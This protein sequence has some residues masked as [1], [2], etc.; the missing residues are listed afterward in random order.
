MHMPPLNFFL[1]FYWLIMAIDGALL[2]IYVSVRTMH[3][4]LNF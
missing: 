2:H 1:P 4:R 3:A